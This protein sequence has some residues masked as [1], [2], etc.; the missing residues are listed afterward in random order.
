[1]GTPVN[2]GVSSPVVANPP[3]LSTSQQQTQGALN[4]TRAGAA[5]EEVPFWFPKETLYTGGLRT[6]HTDDER[7]GN[8]AGEYFLRYTDGFQEVAFHVAPL[9]PTRNATDANCTKKKKHIGNDSVVILICGDSLN[10]KYD[11][12]PLSFRSEVTDVYIIVER[13]GST[14]LSRITVRLR[15]GADPSLVDKMPST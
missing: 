14:E 15:A 4:H 5:G 8:D 3:H 6:A 2:T 1:M 11:S 10:A 12:V 7:K 13:V 9:M